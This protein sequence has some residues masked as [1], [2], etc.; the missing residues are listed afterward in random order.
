MRSPLPDQA[1][2][3]RF[4]RPCFLAGQQSPV[5]REERGDEAIHASTWNDVHGLLRF[6]RNDD[7]G[8]DEPQNPPERSANPSLRHWRARSDELILVMPA[9]AGIQLPS[10]TALA[11]GGQ[12]TSACAK[13]LDARFR[14]H[15]SA[16]AAAADYS[17]RRAHSDE[18]VL[19]M[20]ANAGIHMPR[21]TAA[22]QGRPAAESLASS[23]L[24]H[25]QLRS[26]LRPDLDPP[27]PPPSLL[28]HVK[29]P[30]D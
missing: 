11:R 10:E 27:P 9:K 12:V 29:H 13:S 24:F 22:E 5:H 28:F 17:H 3:S 26:E 25:A 7:K 8:L 18:A 15:D 23:A 19:V 16:T 2:A 6:A 20:P 14:G 4:P 21:E 30:H 1:S